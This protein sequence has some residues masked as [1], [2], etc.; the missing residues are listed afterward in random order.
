MD[1]EIRQLNI[2]FKACKDKDDKRIVEGR[3]IPFGV[4]S[5]NREGFREQIM[6]EAVEGVIE[7]SD[8][9]FL[10]NHDNSKGFL[11]RS[12]KCKGKLSIEVKDDGV[13]FSFPLKNDN[14][15]NYIWERMEDGELDEMSWAFTVAEDRW[16][17]CDDGV[18][19]RYIDKF[20]MLYDFSVVDAS[21]YGI[22]NAVGCKRFAEIQEEERIENEK[23]IAEEEAKA[24]KEKEDALNA[25][26]ENLRKENE[27]YL[28]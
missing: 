5:P 9:R 19:D 17:K 26:Y 8:I 16:V 27:K 20:E 6:P 23:R 4:K 15:S 25:Y 24:Q 1:K 28:N 3:A 21:Y 12:N 2:E 13:Y 14:L 7:K 22:S 11:A 18:Y 10:Y